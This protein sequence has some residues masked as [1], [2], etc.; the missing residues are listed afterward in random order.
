MR[1]GRSRR[2]RPGVGVA[3]GVRRVRVA[4]RVNGH[5]VR[6]WKVCHPL[7]EVALINGRCGGN[8]ELHVVHLG[9]R[10]GACVAVVRGLHRRGAVLCDGVPR[11]GG[12]ANQIK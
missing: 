5:K 6:M 12:V 3:R 7:S 11:A 8:I 1:S 9:Q 2:S 10:A 4:K